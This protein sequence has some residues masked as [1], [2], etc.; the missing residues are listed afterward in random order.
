MNLL[1]LLLFSAVFGRKSTQCRT[2]FSKSG[3]PSANPTLDIES[4][5]TIDYS[6]AES[7][8]GLPDRFLTDKSNPV[9]KT[10]ER[11]ASC[12]NPL[13]PTD[14]AEEAAEVRITP[15]FCLISFTLIGAFPRFVSSG[16]VTNNEESSSI[17]YDRATPPSNNRPRIR[18][19][20]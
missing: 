11:K 12:L 15:V 7:S 8:P 2:I 20:I 19:R 16:K 13:P 9:V 18:T 6:T 5:T 17:V 3:G 14:T 1:Q 10:P 4:G